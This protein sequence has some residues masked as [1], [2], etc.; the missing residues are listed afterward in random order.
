MLLHVDE[1]DL[2]FDYVRN[3]FLALTHE[4]C[5]LC[6]RLGVAECEERVHL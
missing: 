1:D 3:I 4:V 5:C 6:V 2:A